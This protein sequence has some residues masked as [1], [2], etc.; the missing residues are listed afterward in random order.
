MSKEILAALALA[1]TM[2]QAGSFEPREDK[3]IQRISHPGGIP[4]AGRRRGRDRLESPMV[5]VAI[6]P[7][8]GLVGRQFRAL[9]DPTL[10]EGDLCGL[11]RRPL[12][13]HLRD[14]LAGA[15]DCLDEQTLPRLTGHDR[16]PAVAAGGNQSGNNV[17]GASSGTVDAGT[18]NIVHFNWMLPI[19]GFC[20]TM[21]LL[22]G[23]RIVAMRSKV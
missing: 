15:A 1:S 13:R 14:D 7:A 23:E 12:G 22:C 9:V 11:Q 2:L 20:I 8:G 5:A 4:D 16:R 3:G 17:L 19:G 10:E 6:C 18:G 21:T